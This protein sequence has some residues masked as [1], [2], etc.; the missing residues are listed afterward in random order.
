MKVCAHINYGPFQN[1]HERFD[2]IGAA[3]EF[4]REKVVDNRYRE[5][6]TDDADG[7]YT[8]DLNEQCDDCSSME[9]YHDYPM[10]RYDVGPRGG[11][12]KAYI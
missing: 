5:G 1:G 12:R 9:N 4:F 11:L 10:L 3:L 8:I 2:S 6:T 7:C